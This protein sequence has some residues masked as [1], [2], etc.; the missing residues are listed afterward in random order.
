MSFVCYGRFFCF[1]AL[2]FFLRG[3]TPEDASPPAGIPFPL[4]L[5][6]FCVSYVR[7]GSPF[8]STSIVLVTYVS[9]PSRRFFG[10]PKYWK[11]AARCIRRIDR[12]ARR[13]F[14]RCQ[15]G[16]AAGEAPYMYI[17]RYSCSR[18]LRFFMAIF[19]RYIKK[20]C[21]R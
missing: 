10:Y 21:L 5:Y 7:V 1:F 3:W 8:T 18:D 14:A 2:P 9:E 20:K 4:S 11:D 12:H 16:A 19:C 13:P 6:L 15:S 17:Y